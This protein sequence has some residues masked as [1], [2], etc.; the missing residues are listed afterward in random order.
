MERSLH[1]GGGVYAGLRPSSR[2]QQA[3]QRER[4][5]QLLQDVISLYLSSS[6][7]QPS[8]R[9]RGAAALPDPPYYEEPELPLDYVEDY[10]LTELAMARAR[11]QQQLPQHDYSSLAGLDG[12]LVD[13]LS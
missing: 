11:Q 4:D 12:E 7:A 1:Q 5:H 9:H 8:F 10:S 2:Y 3:K 13:L 6:P